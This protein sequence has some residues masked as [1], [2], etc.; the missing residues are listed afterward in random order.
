MA[1]GD[2]RMHKEWRETTGLRTATAACLSRGVHGA[3]RVRG[4]AALGA[5]AECGESLVG[6]GTRWSDG[7]R[8]SHGTL[9]S[10]GYD[11]SHR[12]FGR[13][14]CGTTSGSSSGV[15]TPAHGQP[16]PPSA[17]PQRSVTAT[18]SGDSRP[19]DTGGSRGSKRRAGSRG[20]ESGSA[21][22]GSK[23]KH[24]KK[25]PREEQRSRGVRFRSREI[26]LDWFREQDMVSLERD[27][28]REGQNGLVRASNL[29][30][31]LLHDGLAGDEYLEDRRKSGWDAWIQDQV[32][33]AVF[34]TTTT[35]DLV[36]GEGTGSREDGPQ[37]RE[38]LEAWKS[39]VDVVKAKGRAKVPSFLDKDLANDITTRG[40]GGVLWLPL[41]A[42]VV[43]VESLEFQGT[44]GVVRRVRITGVPFIPESLEFAGKSMKV[45]DART[46]RIE[47]SVEA[48]SCPVDHPGVIKIHYLNMSTLEAYSLW[49]NGGSV[50]SM[51]TFDDK[52]GGD[53][54]AEI[55]KEAG[56]D[57]EAR[58]KLVVYRKNRAFLAWALMCIVDVVH[59]YNVL[60]NDISA[61][62]VMLHFPDDREGTVFIGV[63]DW[64]MATF[65]CEAAPS[66]YGA[67]SREKMT[68]MMGAYDCAAPELFHVHG[69]AGARG[70]SLSPVRM[71]RAHPHTVK[72]ESFSVGMLARKIYKSDSTSHL[73]QQN[74]DPDSVKMRF[75]SALT[76]LTHAD[77]AARR[78]IS[79]VVNILKSHPYD[80]RTPTMC[81]RNS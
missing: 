71:S 15:Q 74:R 38:K 1:D 33:E 2:A 12:S 60:H 64:G 63:C 78:S 59:S 52:I 30:N 70:T 42:V 22:S 73:F 14:T 47:R 69:G 4:G 79:E 51:R 49:W 27:Y 10:R 6:P 48:L 5:A 23:S 39:G 58:K 16:L 26:L 8:R 13:G 44:Y 76:D 20:T 53:H 54:S 66:N 57:Y 80:L 21:A 68:T 11:G 37:L 18:P 7:N 72:S 75:E 24:R 29:F 56:P 45:K 28:L 65:R 17:P 32:Q 43:Q 50:R 55:L 67:D 31:R 41:D 61:S 25:L 40:R 34:N 3:D 77:P 19:A 35:F 62:N 46:S 81:F 9:E 36:Y